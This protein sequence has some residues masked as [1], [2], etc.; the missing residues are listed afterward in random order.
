MSHN[1]YI[2]KFFI[3]WHNYDEPTGNLDSKNSENIINLLK[4]LNKKLK[5]TLVIVTH[6]LEIAKQADRILELKDGK[7]VSNT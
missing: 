2:F 3:F 1:L 6:N 4:N 7:I 5:Q